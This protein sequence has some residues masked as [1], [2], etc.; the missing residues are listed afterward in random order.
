MLQEKPENLNEKELAMARDNQ[1]LDERRRFIRLSYKTPLMYKVCKQSTIS[2]LMEGY[3]HNISQAGLMCNINGTIPKVG[4]LWL[5]LDMGA[6]SLCKEI[7]K[8]CVIIQQGILGEVAWLKKISKDSYDV[9]VRFI[10]REEKSGLSQ[11]QLLAVYSENQISKKVQS[12][13]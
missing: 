11:Q 7:E 10:T 2:K 1:D 3:I 8:S 6:L 13:K 4:T 5:K 9:G 12:D